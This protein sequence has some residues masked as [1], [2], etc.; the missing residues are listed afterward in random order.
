MAES[1]LEIRPEEMDIAENV[2][3]AQLANF[4][5]TVATIKTQVHTNLS[6]CSG[7]LYD[8]LKSSYDTQIQT[9]ME[10]TRESVEMY[11]KNMRDASDRL[12]ET[13]NKVRHI[14]ES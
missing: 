9:M 11:I 7:D 3:R 10:D 2:M 5:K 4:E 12:D 14:L 6:E 8:S 1:I 13:T